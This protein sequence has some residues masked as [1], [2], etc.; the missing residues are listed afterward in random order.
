[1]N[2]LRTGS[3]AWARSCPALFT[4]LL[5][6]RIKHLWASAFKERLVSRL[7]FILTP[8]YR[9]PL[10]KLGQELLSDYDHRPGRPSFIL[11]QLEREKSHPFQKSQ[12]NGRLKYQKLRRHDL[13]KKW[14][15]PVVQVEP[16]QQPTSASRDSR[17]WSNCQPF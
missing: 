4:D 13:L 8:N 16:S 15:S 10:V 14:V 1:M 5:A 2:C 12:I 6:L 11:V 7:L 9:T 3:R 17:S